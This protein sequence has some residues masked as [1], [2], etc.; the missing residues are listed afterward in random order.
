MLST[1]ARARVAS[2]YN[3]NRASGGMLFENDVNFTEISLF[4]ECTSLRTL[5]RRYWK[6]QRAS[7]AKV[8]F[9]KFNLE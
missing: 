2:V 3:I 4:T 1:A 6:Q 7:F 9:Q 5:S 8:V